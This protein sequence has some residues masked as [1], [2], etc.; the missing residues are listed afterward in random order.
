MNYPTR[1]MGIASLVVGLGALT[2][3]GLGFYDISQRPEPEMTMAVT[4]YSTARN[5]K[6]DAERIIYEFRDNIYR[7][8]D[9]RGVVINALEEK[10][11]DYDKVMNRNS[12]AYQSW[13]SAWDE[14]FEGS[15][16]VVLLGVLGLG[17]LTSG[18][19]HILK[20]RKKSEEKK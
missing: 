14:K 2:K 17:L 1:L 8:L 11:K 10:I 7:D 16:D 6:S 19:V 3:A 18:F 5:Q 12:S 13:E 4:E 20:S 15:D 9:N